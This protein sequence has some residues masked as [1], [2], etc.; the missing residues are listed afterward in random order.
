MRHVN[1]TRGTYSCNTLIVRENARWKLKNDS[2]RP[3]LQG[4]TPTQTE[5]WVRIESTIYAEKCRAVFQDAEFVSISAYPSSYG[6][7]TMVSVLHSHATN[8]CCVPPIKGITKAKLPDIHLEDMVD[9]IVGQDKFE[10]WSAYTE[11]RALSSQLAD[12]IGDPSGIHRFALP[13]VL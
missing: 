9:D 1:H 8:T 10:R 6:E 12:T 7:S 2:D 3:H 11:L 5:R 13:E 4:I